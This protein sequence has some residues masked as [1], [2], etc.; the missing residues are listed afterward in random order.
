MATCRSVP[1]RPTAKDAAAITAGPVRKRT[2]M[3]NVATLFPHAMIRGCSA[4]N[5]PAHTTGGWY[6][7]RLNMA[8]PSPASDR[9]EMDFRTIAGISKF[10]LQDDPTNPTAE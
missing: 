7:P 2:A 10:H 5:S 6:R 1:R 8:I 9:M 4:M 3:A